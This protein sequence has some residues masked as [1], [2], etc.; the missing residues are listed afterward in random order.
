MASSSL[1]HDVNLSK[2]MYMY[3][4]LICFIKMYIHMYIYNSS[5]FVFIEG[6]CD[7]TLLVTG[8]TGSGKSS[9]CNFLS[10]SKTAFETANGFA[11]IT[12]KSAAAIITMQGKRV[13]LIDTPGFC[14]DYETEEEHMEELISDAVVLASKGVNA[15]GLVINAME[16]YTTNERSTIEQISQYQELWS[17]MFI[18][19][20]HARSLGVSEEDQHKQLHSNLKASRCPESLKDLMQKVSDRYIL[21]ESIKPS[22]D[23]ED[24]YQRKTKEIE[25]MMISI[26]EA[27][28][29]QLYTNELFNSAKVVLDKLIKERGEAK[30]ELKM[31]RSTTDENIKK[32]LEDEKTVQEAKQKIEM[33]AEKQKQIEQET[34]EKRKTILADTNEEMLQKVKERED[35]KKEL[36]QRYLEKQQLEKKLADDQIKRQAIENLKKQLEEERKQYEALKTEESKGKPNKKWY[37]SLFKKSTENK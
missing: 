3:C 37:K 14:D 24:Y 13:K 36:D 9:L 26:Y 19:F 11:S 32:R 5:N 30:V 28:G 35:V 18:I 20:T 34:V 16:R 15:I 17:Y 23:P 10:C 25:T 21:V 7:Y 31:T 1:K 27:N 29:F 2:G 22:D 6:N 4:I 12:E 8:V 33:A